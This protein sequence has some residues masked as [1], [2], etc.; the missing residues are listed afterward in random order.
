[1]NRPRLF[2]T[3]A[4]RKATLRFSMSN[5]VF[6]TDEFPA[7]FE[8]A[9]EAESSAIPESDAVVA[10]RELFHVYYRLERDAAK[11]TFFR[12]LTGSTLSYSRIGILTQVRQ[13]VIAV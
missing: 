12:F 5:F 11:N 9:T 8:S 13:T 4:E 1:M 10:V 6:L 2:A 3:F 7:V